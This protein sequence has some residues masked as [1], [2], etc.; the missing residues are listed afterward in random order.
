M[1]IGIFPNCKKKAS[2]DILDRM[3][4]FFEKQNADVFLPQEMAEL[5]SCKDIGVKNILN[6]D[7]DV[8]IS[9]GGDGTLLG[10]CRL[11]APHDIP[12]CGI[13]IGTLGFLADI[14]VSELE[15]KLIKI[16][17]GNYN[18]EQRLMLAGYIKK[19]N[20][21]KLAGYAVNDIVLTSAGVARMVGLELEFDSYKVPSYRADGLI[22]S[23]A[24]GSTA[25]SLSA[26]GPIINPKVKVLLVTPI[27]PHTF[28][29]RPMIINETEEINIKVKD[30]SQ[31]VILTFDGQDV[32]P[33]SSDEQVMICRAPFS[34]KIIKFDDKNYYK[35]LLNKLIRSNTNA[36]AQ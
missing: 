9:I 6:A 5:F 11:L 12:V 19:D 29:V 28:Y 25:Y 17:N 13:N 22:V 16:L 2:K 34:A 14:E 3:R 1:R 24:T 4:I 31:D 33:I 8:G 30:T 21:L 27:C 18:I 36:D 35:I 7:I 26:G 20:A 10:V 15:N 32:Y 23:T